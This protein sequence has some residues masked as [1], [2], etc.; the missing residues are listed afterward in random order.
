MLC[1]RC[2][3]KEANVHITKIINGVKNEMHLCDEC[4]RETQEVNIALPLNFGMPMSFQNI[5]EGFMEMMGGIPQQLVEDTFCPVCHMTFENFRKTG[6]LG[7][8]NCYSAFSENMIPLVRR[9]HGN[10][11]HTG[12]VPKRSG[13]VLKVKRDIERLKEELKIAVAN[14]EYEKAARIRDE[15]R[16]LEGLIKDRKDK[17]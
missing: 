15:I 16:H 5:L 11:Q 17:E 6:R 14:E 13:G 12:K 1:Q 7:C 4:A 8:G 3:K 2:Q 10:I 9:I